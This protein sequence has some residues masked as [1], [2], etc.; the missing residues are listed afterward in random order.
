MPFLLEP[1]ESSSLF[2]VPVMV[3]GNGPLKVCL[4]NLGEELILLK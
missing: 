3:E 1:K 2:A 4:V